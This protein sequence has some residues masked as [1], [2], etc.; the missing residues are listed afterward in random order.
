MERLEQLVTLA[1]SLPG[2]AFIW[3]L[4][5]LHC[6]GTCL[7]QD[8]GAVDSTS[9]RKGPLVK[10]SADGSISEVPKAELDNLPVGFP[11]FQKLSVTRRENRWIVSGTTCSTN[12]GSVKPSVAIYVCYDNGQF[13]LAAISNLKGE[14]LFDA[15]TADTKGK[16]VS[17]AYLFIAG[18]VSGA[19][20]VSP[21]TILRKYQFRTTE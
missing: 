15:T 3:T 19:F 13:S 11:A 18:H 2:L 12:T 21:G 5:I 1:R 4:M 17:P 14:V 10:V 9:W 7:A 16:T 20:S 6:C 8:P